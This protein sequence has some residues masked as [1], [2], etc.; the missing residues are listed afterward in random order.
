[1][2]PEAGLH[3]SNGPLARIYDV[4]LLDL[5][6]VVYVGHTAVPGAR[7]ALS[8][9]RAAGM[10]LAFV[11]NNASRT[12]RTVADLLTRLGV[13]AAPE[14]V[15]TSA[16]AAARLV[17]E[18][19]PPGSRVLLVGAEG[20]EQALVEQGLQPVLTADEHPAAVAQGYG[21]DVGW[22]NLA[23]AAYAIQEGAWW[24]ATNTDLTLPTPRGTAP[25]NGAMVAAVRYATG[26]APVVAGKPELPMHREGILRTGATR[27]LVVGDR[28]DT[29]IEGARRAGVDSLLVLTGVTRPIDL[30]QAAPGMRPTFVAGDLSGLLDEHP[31]VAFHDAAVRCRGWTA[32]ADERGVHLTPPDDVVGRRPVDGLRAV[33][34]AVWAADPPPTGNDVETALRQAGIPLVWSGD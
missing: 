24:V 23:E 15:V 20:L 28:L 3:A 27:P 30:V 4:A 25:G 12:P 32:R 16:Q 29:D 18:R 8:A 13:P 22:R 5:D 11:T 17:A 9:A 2:A 26:V 10:R 33:C 14:E 19:L 1:L 6:G 7:D 34:V 31:D 21:P